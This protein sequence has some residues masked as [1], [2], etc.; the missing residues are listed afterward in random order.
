MRDLLITRNKTD[1]VKPLIFFLLVSALVPLAIAPEA[2]R[3]AQLAPVL[4]GFLLCWRLYSLSSV[5]LAM[6]YT[7]VLFRANADI[8]QPVD[9]SI[10][11]QITAHW[12]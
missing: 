11:G 10:L 9:T 6:I 4:F 8:P 3:L 12:S 5:F 2:N 7:M 1:L